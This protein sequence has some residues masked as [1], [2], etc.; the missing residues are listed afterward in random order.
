MATKSG[1]PPNSAMCSLTQASAR[2]TSTIASGHVARGREPVAH[3][4]A[5]PASLGQV[6]HQR[7]RLR[8]LV[9]GDPRAARHLQQDR[10]LR[11]SRQIVAVPD[12]EQVG[13]ARRSVRDV[14]VMRESPPDRHRAQGTRAAGHAGWRLEPRRMDDPLLVVRAERLSQRLSQMLSARRAGTCR[15]ARPAHEAAVNPSAAAR[16]RAGIRRQIGAVAATIAA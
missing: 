10:C 12:V 1:S 6:T 2:L 15:A 13:L 9:S 5:D 14:L 3:R 16:R 11:G 7:V 8:L 4:H